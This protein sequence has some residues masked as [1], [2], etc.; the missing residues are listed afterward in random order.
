M[1]DACDED[2]GVMLKR[3]SR[4]SPQVLPR[5]KRHLPFSV[6]ETHSA[7]TL[8]PVLVNTISTCKKAS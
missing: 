2:V 3:I 5:H 8:F 7:R 6:S 1:G 4:S